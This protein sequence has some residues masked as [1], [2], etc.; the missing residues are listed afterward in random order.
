VVKALKALIKELN[1][2]PALAIF[3]TW[4]RTLGGDDSA[5]SDA[6]GVAALDALRGRFD[7]FAVLVVHHEGHLKGRSRGWSGLRAAVDVEFRAER[8]KDELLR[9]ECTKS[10]DT[11]PVDPMAFQFAGVDLG[12]TDEKGNP[13]SSAI[14]NQ[15]DYTPALETA[16]AKPAGKNQALALDILKRLETEARKNRGDDGRVSLDWWRDEC[17]LEGIVKQRFYDVRVSLEKAGKIKVQD[18]F[19]Y[20]ISPVTNSRS[21]PVTVPPLLYSGGYRT[22]T[23]IMDEV[24]ENTETLPSVTVTEKGLGVEDPVLTN[25][26]GC[27]PEPPLEPE[28]AIW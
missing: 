22:V 2:V 18:L 26:S 24:T 3:D 7:N 19:V 16:T 27:Q 23:G 17:K 8:G 14:L 6:A 5:P 28:L 15:I 21:C 11:R 1:C 25:A 13:I 12:I 9:L 4:S 10:K 20:S